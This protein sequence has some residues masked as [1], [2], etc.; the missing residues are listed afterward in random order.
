MY[1][2]FNVEEPPHKEVL[3]ILL[4]RGWDINA[5]RV[6][7]Q[8]FLWEVV[9]DGDMVAWCLEHGASPTAQDLNLETEDQRTTDQMGCPPILELAARRS[10]V[11]T[12]ELLR[13]REVPLG[14][15]MLHLAAKAAVNDGSAGDDRADMSDKERAGT[16]SERMDMLVHLI[17]TLKLDPNA[18]DQPSGWSLGNH[19]GTPLCYVA[20]SNPNWDCSDAVRY[21]LSKGADPELVVEPAGW[22]AIELAR[23]SRN[24]RFLDIVEDWTERRK[25]GENA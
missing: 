17:D 23:R 25:Q 2:N 1:S 14:R 9:G 7:E 6:N 5:R 16:L 19:W 13:S 11:A 3:E 18:L 12:F 10:T 8:P 24:Q 21:L 15:R 22:N 20:N 4:S